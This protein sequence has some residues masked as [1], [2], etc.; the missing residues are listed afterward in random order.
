MVENILSCRPSSYGAFALQGLEHLPEI[1][2]HYIERGLPGKSDNI[3]LIKGMLEDL[4]LHVASFD[5]G[6]DPLGKNFTEQID[7]AIAACDE[8]DTKVIFTSI[9]GDKS[10]KKNA[11]LF[12]QLRVLGDRVQEHGIRVC[13]E[14]HPNLVPNGTTGKATMEGIH[15]DSIRINYDTANMY[16]YN[17]NIDPVK[18]LDLIANYV[19]S[20]HL[21]DTDGKFHTWCFPTL[22]EGVVKFTDV[23]S[24]LNAVDFHGPYTMEIEGVRGEHLDLEQTKARMKKSVEFIQAILNP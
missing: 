21:K 4:D 18:E 19:G 9:K 1:G 2:V 5:A 14:T 13:L 12:E 3:E 17:K 20:V 16:Y 8:F 10:P 22:G 7:Q 11:K 23:V 6:F 15:H 24:K